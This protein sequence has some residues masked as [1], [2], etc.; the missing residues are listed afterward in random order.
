MAEIRIDYNKCVNCKLCIKACTSKAIEMIDGKIVINENCN[1]CSACIT[2]CKFGALSIVKEQLEDNNTGCYYGIWVI[3]EHFNNK[4]A[5]VSLELIAEAKRLSEGFDCIVTAIILGYNVEKYCD[6]LIAYGAD[7]VIVVNRKELDVHDELVYADTLTKLI[8]KYQPNIILI[9]ATA[10]GRNLAP[11]V[12][13][14]VTTGLTA[15]CTQLKLD[16]TGTLLYQTR[17]AFGGNLMATIICPNHRPQMATVRPGIFKSLP[18]IAERKGRVI[19]EGFLDIPPV[20]LKYLESIPVVRSGV[21]ITTAEVIVVAGKG[22][23]GKENIKPLQQLACM[24]GGALGATRSVVD[25]GWLPYDNQIG[26]TGKTVNPKLI[27]TCGVSGAI[28]FVSGISG[29]ETIIAINNDIE[30]DIFKIA[31]YNV[32][33]DFL[34]VVDNLINEIK[35]NGL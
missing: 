24:L 12:A 21:D 20:M 34:D 2:N 10:W 25:A 14:K 32:F 4:T 17:P 27:I 31:H 8:K 22:V 18:Y 9:G 26:Q 35:S 29:A 19:Q 13:A 23:G 7:E 1:F 28:Q 16:R 3:V 5:S 11:I 30:A 33:G 15:D 6:D